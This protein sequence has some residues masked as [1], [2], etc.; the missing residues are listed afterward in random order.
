MNYRIAVCDD[1]EP[2]AR[3]LSELAARWAD[4]AGAEVEVER[5]PSAEAFLFRNEVEKYVDIHHLDIEMNG[6]DGVALALEK[7]VL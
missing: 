3:Y 4:R 6:K 7:F 5:F 1:D 2:Y